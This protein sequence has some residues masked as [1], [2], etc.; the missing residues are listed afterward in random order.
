MDKIVCLFGPH[1]VQFIEN[2]V[3]ISGMETGTEFYGHIAPVF[4][5]IHIIHISETIRRG[6]EEIKSNIFVRQS[7]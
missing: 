6:T 1:L 2:F 5:F 4:I 3:H 7:R